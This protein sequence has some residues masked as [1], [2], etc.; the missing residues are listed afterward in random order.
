MSQGREQHPCCGNR[1]S[2]CCGFIRGKDAIVCEGCGGF[3][4]VACAGYRTYEQARND[5][6]RWWCYECSTDRLI[7]RQSS[8]RAST[9]SQPTPGINS[10]IPNLVWPPLQHR[11]RQTPAQVRTRP[12]FHPVATSTALSGSP[13]IIASA[14][15]PS[16]STVAH[17]AVANSPQGTFFNTQ[18]DLFSQGSEVVPYSPSTFSSHHSL[19]LPFT[20]SPPS[21]NPQSDFLPAVVNSPQ[22]SEVVPYSPPSTFSSH[23]P[24]ALPLTHSP[25]SPTQLLNFSPSHSPLYHVC[26][27]QLD[28]FTQ[29]P[30]GPGVVTPYSPLALSPPQS[31]VIPLSLTHSPPSPTSQVTFSPSQSTSYSA[32]HIGFSQSY[33]PASPPHPLPVSQIP[34][35]AHSPP[36]LPPVLPPPPPVPRSCLP[37]ISAQASLSPTSLLNR[38]AEQESQNS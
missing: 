12:V 8:L 1:T 18:Q 17:T 31:S 25:L 26:N 22:G 11:N 9:S 28:L 30:K 20:H 16:L 34:L 6:N 21:L 10:R 13:V 35:P 3:S 38:I 27:T 37:A 7:P 19:A 2:K 33:G 29:S 4:H 14:S 24:L 15:R 32:H 36:V 5:E 23:R